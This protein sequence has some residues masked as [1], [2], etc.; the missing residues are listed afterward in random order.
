MSALPPKADICGA[1]VHVR[2]CRLDLCFVG[3]VYKVGAMA[4]IARNIE[5]YN[6]AYSLAWKH[7]RA[8]ETRTAGYSSTS[9]RF[10]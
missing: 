10:H 3:K 4:G 8:S 1:L 9:S 5:L 6:L 2:D 7:F